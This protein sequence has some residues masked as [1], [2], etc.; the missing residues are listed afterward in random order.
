MFNKGITKI[1]ILLVSAIVIIIVIVDF[2]VISH[3]QK[4][5]QDIQIL[6]EIDQIRSGLEIFLFVNNY[7]P[8][9]DEPVSLNDSYAGTEKL[10]LSGFEKFNTDCQKNILNPIPNKY[11]NEDNIYLYKSIEDG[12]NYQI[13]FTLDT[14]FKNQ[15]L[16]KGKNCATNLQITSQA[17]F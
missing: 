15:G 6:S 12:Q 17:C 8:L 4:K 13:E 10:C 2:V 3:L 1:E 14:D 9:A 5:E 7:Y 11:L 16:T